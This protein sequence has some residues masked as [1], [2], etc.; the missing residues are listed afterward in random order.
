MQAFLNKKILNM[1]QTSIEQEETTTSEGTW[2]KKVVSSFYFILA[3]STA[4]E[5]SKEWKQLSEAF[6]EGK[7]L[8]QK[9]NQAYRGNKAKEDLNFVNPEKIIKALQSIDGMAQFSISTE[10][11][12][13]SGTTVEIT[14]EFFKTVLSS[15]DGNVSMVSDFLTKQMGELQAKAKKQHN[16]KHLGIMFVLVSLDPFG[17]PSFTL[18][19]AYV[20]DKYKDWVLKLLCGSIEKYSYDFK[21]TSVK[22]T[23]V[24]PEK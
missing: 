4:K 19:Y 8:I 10:D 24:P 3:W 16:A 2:L 20:S 21:Y 1:S 7:Q 22:Y 6:E 12:N 11:Q 5:G 23:Y 17:Y 9:I 13:E 14:N 18:Q 15:L